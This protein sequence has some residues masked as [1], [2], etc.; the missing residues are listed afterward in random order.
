MHTTTQLLPATVVLNCEVTNVSV[1]GAGYIKDVVL[2]IAQGRIAYAVLGFGGFLGLGEKVVAV[3][4]E[5]LTYDAD[6]NRF[7]VNVSREKLEN[8][9]GYD[10]EQLPVI[11]DP[12][13]GRLIYAYYGYEPYW[14]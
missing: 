9:E 11:A 4:W 10:P 6:N 8:A 1:E 14:I 13:Q 5:A 3:P 7:I 12:D 2:D